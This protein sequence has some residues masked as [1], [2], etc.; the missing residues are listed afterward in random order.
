MPNSLSKELRNQ[1]AKVTVAARQRADEAVRAALQNLAVHERDYRPHMSVP[2]RQLR[3]KLRAKG[4][5]LGDSRDERAGTQQ[6]GHLAEQ[7][8]YEHWHRLLFT[9]F[10]VENG[11]LYSDSSFG[12]VPVTLQECD[13]LAPDAGARDGF[14][15]ACR[16]A[17]RTLPG[18]FRKDD[19]VLELR[20]APNDETALR[21]LLDSLPVQVF[22]SDDGLGWTY[23]FWQSQRKDEVNASG[24][25][26]GADELPAVT[27]LFTEDYMVEFLLHNTLG[28]WWAGRIGPISAAT[29][30]DARSKAALPAKEGLGI[31]WTYLRFVQDEQT[32]TWSPAAG[33]FPGWPA[34]TKLITFLDP[35]MGSGHFLVFALPL[36][37]RMRMEE[38]GVSAAQAVHTSI[39]DNLFGLEL[40]E[41][42]AQIAAFNLALT[43]WRIGGHQTLPTPH[44]ACSGL[45]PN[46]TE[47]DW[48]SLAGSD[49]RL[50]RGMSRLFALFKDAPVLGSLIDPRAIVGDLVNADF[51]EL[52]PVLTK[53]VVQTA[54]D[55][56]EHEIAVTAQGLAKAAEILDGRFALVATNVP[57]LG[58]GKQD[59]VLLGY[60]DRYHQEAKADLATSFL[61]RCLRFCVEGG[62]SA[63]VTPQNWLFLG[64]YKA[65]RLKLLNSTRLDVVAR[66]GE[67]GFE[68][69]QAAGA[70]VALCSITREAPSKDHR[71]AGLDVSE[72]DSPRHK[73]NSLRVGH[74]AALVQRSQSHNP[75][76]R[77][78]LEPGKAGVLLSTYASAFV[79]LQNGDSPRFILYFWE[80]PSIG[81][82]W[83]PFQL[84]CDQTSPFGGRE[85]VLR[86]DGG[87]GELAESDGC[88]IKGR[89][90]WGKKGVAIRH[91]RE[92]P[93]TLYS[94]DLYDQNSAAIIPKDEAL[95]PAIW[96]FC[97]STA[98]NLAV[99]RVDKA[100]KV[101]NST[102]VKVPFDLAHWQSIAA[103]AYPRGLPRPS[104]SD[105]TQWL[106]DGLPVGADQPLHAAV[107]R[108]LGYEWPRRAGSSFPDCSAL[109]RDGLEEFCDGDGVVCLSAINKEEP[110]ASRLR[111]L[112]A[113]TLGALD[114]R[115]LVVSAGPSGSKS[116]TIEGW[117][118]DE[119]FEQHC[120][121]FH[122]RPFVWH[123]WDGRQDGFHALVNYHRLDQ[124]SLTKLTYSYLGDWI[125]QQEQ[126]A[127][128]DLPGAAHRLG[129]AQELQGE[130]AKILEGEAPRDI[131]VRWKP[132]TKQAIGWNPDLN[133]GV[134]MNIRPFL[135]APDVGK[136]GAGLLRAKPNIKWDKDRGKEPHRDKADYPWF[137]CESEPGRDPQP[138][139]AFTGHRWNDVHL[140]LAAKRAAKEN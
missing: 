46:A 114:E 2:D 85:G 16:F 83:E 129:A 4:R 106:F 52:Q 70:F 108:L 131:F 14:D 139:R 140:T 86:W 50:Q 135:T 64:T 27:Q 91:M 20:L 9:R 138:G 77:I 23:Q 63:L 41:R 1:L 57:Y 67:N 104:S 56:F 90:A 5:A 36:F 24:K 72:E 30:E 128:A 78:I 32:K 13:E 73:D 42:C 87:A 26:I 97:S 98:F 21:A 25:K 79:G 113:R 48:V 68:S 45:A 82:P 39:Q 118:R 92:L 103:D 122:Q 100:I 119:F 66:L 111:R 102:L 10:L 44:L 115:A 84:P 49:D 35:C 38:E 88:Y 7:A 55:D 105:L 3:N 137:W 96:A 101:T 81:L 93:A 47:K 121:L 54:S 37:V 43:A 22:Q 76:S 11:L 51:G 109:G 40:D 95:L 34:K 132:L 60:C 74:V 117:L 61:Q 15:L 120:D 65:L 99:R 125:R 80:L 53:A 59:E 75:D 112:L 107:A 69:P 18:V 33:T 31:T 127:K 116:Q 123:I 8:A 6:I 12:E 89:E 19:P 71:F 136:K 130:L 133:D 17:A 126:G 29:E 134:R 94:G 124:A 58:R 62:S 28:A 110:A